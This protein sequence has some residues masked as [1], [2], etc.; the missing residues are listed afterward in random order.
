MRL[1]AGRSFKI[2]QGKVLIPAPHNID[3]AQL[4][5]VFYILE[6]A[7]NGELVV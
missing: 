5:W 7:L 3:A 2:G 1:L 6:A 4:W